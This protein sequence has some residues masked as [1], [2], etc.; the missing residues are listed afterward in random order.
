VDLQIDR[1]AGAQGSGR[2]LREAILPGVDYW[3]MWLF[4]EF[5]KTIEEFQNMFRQ[6]KADYFWVSGDRGS[7]KSELVVH[8]FKESLNQSTKDGLEYPRIPLYISLSNAKL[9]EDSGVDDGKINMKLF[10]Y[11]CRE[12]IREAIDVIAENTETEHY[13]ELRDVLNKKSLLSEMYR[14]LSSDSFEMAMFVEFINSNSELRDVLRFVIFMDDID[15][16]DTSIGV[17][18]FENSQSNFSELKSY[19]V[20]IVS[21]VQRDFIRMARSRPGM[22]YCL[23]QGEEM[24]NP[25]EFRVPNLNELTNDQVQEFIL[26]RIKYLHLN[27][28]RDWH[29][30]STQPP[31]KSADEVIDDEAWSSFD[32]RKMRQNGT[33]MTLNAWLAMQQAD[34]QGVDF[35]SVLRSVHVVLNDCKVAGQELTSSRLEEIL[36]QRSGREVSAINLELGKRIDKREIPDGIIREDIDRLYAIKDKGGSE[37]IDIVS[38][39]QDKIS[40]GTWVTSSVSAMSGEEIGRG[41]RIKHELMGNFGKKPSCIMAFAEIVAEIGSNPDFLKKEVVSRSP[42]EVCQKF[43]IDD[44]IAR[45]ESSLTSRAAS[46]SR[47]EG[48]RSKEVEAGEGSDAEE[49]P[50]EENRGRSIYSSPSDTV[51][52]RAYNATF[53]EFGMEEWRAAVEEIDQRDHTMFGEDLC[54]NLVREIFREFPE[55]FGKWG[56]ARRDI[57]KAFATDRSA[58]VRRFLGWFSIRGVNLGHI[59]VWDA[60]VRSVT[61]RNLLH[62]LEEEDGL[63]A[64]VECVPATVKW[65]EL[66]AVMQQRDLYSWP[67]GLHTDF[68]AIHEKNL[69]KLNNITNDP[70][71][72]LNFDSESWYVS[73]FRELPNP[74]WSSETL[75]E[76]ASDFGKYRAALAIKV[77]DNL[78]GLLVDGYQTDIEIRLFLFTKNSVDLLERLPLITSLSE[79]DMSRNVA[80]LQSQPR[81]FTRKIED[82]LSELAEKRIAEG[83]EAGDPGI[84]RSL[85]AAQKYAPQNLKVNFSL[86]IEV[87]N[88]KEFF[89]DLTSENKPFNW[90]RGGEYVADAEGFLVRKWSFS[91]GYKYIDRLIVH[92]RDEPEGTSSIVIPKVVVDYSYDENKDSEDD[93]KEVDDGRGE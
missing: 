14:A 66:S 13:S 2:L 79:S 45:L 59:P 49:T 43:R 6:G 42:D 56:D 62:L 72:I 3:E 63:A 74:K 32:I 20:T 53:S 7:G 84:H 44:L 87:E 5:D 41:L 31:H 86:H 76:E 82:A 50:K 52:G 19:G 68:S 10:D 90:V 58:F 93:S 75:L 21:S 37:W 22:N 54:Y 30:D 89:N 33:L 61:G 11:C 85:F 57:E 23:H 4:R 12:A 8:L 17:Q 26:H 73:F 83:E 24:S 88:R 25:F 91:H 36:K 1:G 47:G 92:F 28:N 67:T 9:R 18:F 77:T 70:E 34:T 64:L 60:L 71:G 38:L 39:I 51:V 80:A 48:K 81:S 16:I 78:R 55:K 27:N 15:K 46:Q 35:R 40:L 69:G 65:I 29:L